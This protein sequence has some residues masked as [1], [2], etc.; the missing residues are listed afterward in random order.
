MLKTKNLRVDT[1]TLLRYLFRLVTTRRDSSGTGDAPFPP[2]T[3]RID[4]EALRRLRKA[5]DLT[6]GALIKLWGRK[7]AATISRIEKGRREL[8]MSEVRPYLE[9]LG[10]EVAD[11][12]AVRN[13]VV[14]EWDSNPPPG[15][16]R[17]PADEV[18]E[19]RAELQ[20]AQAEAA[21]S[22]EGR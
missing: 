18:R 10:K 12:N 7:A 6:Q 19:A 16:E 2:M 20:R 17:P 4:G 14:L 15:G 13:L 21:R 5:T 3:R 1:S 11:F 9:A 22:D 8:R